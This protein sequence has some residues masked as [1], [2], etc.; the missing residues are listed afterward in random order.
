MVWGGLQTLAPA[1]LHHLSVGEDDCSVSP[2]HNPV[3]VCGRNCI[4][5]LLQLFVMHTKNAG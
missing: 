2:L 5:K 1:N 4:L 3:C